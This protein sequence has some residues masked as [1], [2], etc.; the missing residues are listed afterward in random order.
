MEFKLI[1]IFGHSLYRKN[2]NQSIV[3]PIHHHPILTRVAQTANTSLP[4]ITT[5]VI[6]NLV[7]NVDIS[8]IIH[9][10]KDLQFT[11]RYFIEV[12]NELGVTTI[13]FIEHF[14]KTNKHVEWFNYITLSPLSRCPAGR[15]HD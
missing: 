4:A 11:S 13:K 10:Y 6:E 12:C 5:T 1:N 3:V 9:A 8:T 2:C 15:Q 14:P 7:S